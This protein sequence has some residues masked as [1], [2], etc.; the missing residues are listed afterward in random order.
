MPSLDD[1]PAQR[2]ENPVIYNFPPGFLKRQLPNKVLKIVGKGDLAELRQLLAEHPE[3]L[4]KRGGHNR[5]L[6]WEAVRRGKLASVHWLIEQ[7]ADVDATGCYNGESYL[8]LT[9]YCAAVY[10]RR[11]A[12][13]DYLAPHAAPPDIFR[14]AF[15][16]DQAQIARELAAQPDLLNAEDPHD[17]TYYV[18]LLAFAIVGGHAALVE[19]L[20]ERGAQVP[21]YSAQLI[22]LAARDARLDILDLLVT[23]GADIRVVDG[24]IAVNIDDL[25]VL[26]TLLEHGASPSKPGK[27]RQTPLIYLLRGDKGEHPDKIRLL[28]EYGA[29]VNAADEHG[30]TA[31]DHARESGYAQ[32]IPM[33]IERGAVSGA[34]RL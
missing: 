7:G 20:L 28:L 8:Q 23:H 15:L 6:L 9:P 13:A 1:L 16:G 22:N 32:I 5:T 27:N 26:R 33:L 34:N 24:G 14:A 12:I 25:N 21:I 11:S 3:F 2:W 10:Y 18:P 29:D 17:P 30:K 4:N 19:F 31:L